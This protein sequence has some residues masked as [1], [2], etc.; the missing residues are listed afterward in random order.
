MHQIDNHPLL[1]VRTETVW[2]LVAAK[3]GFAVLVTGEEKHCR[4]LESN[5]HGRREKNPLVQVRLHFKSSD[6][7]ETNAYGK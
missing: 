2:R 1:R 6:L 5:A 4:I 7:S 3:S